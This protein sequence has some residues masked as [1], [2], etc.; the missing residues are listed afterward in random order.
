MI[1][2]ISANDAFN[3]DENYIEN[4]HITTYVDF[5]IKH[6]IHYDNHLDQKDKQSLKFS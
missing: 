1:I 6:Y 2:H 5:F 4:N 3:K